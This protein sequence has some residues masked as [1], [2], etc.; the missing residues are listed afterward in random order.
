MGSRSEINKNAQTEVKLYLAGPEVFL[1]DAAE[2]AQ[3]QKNLCTRYGFIGL[4]PM[5]NNIDIENGSYDTAMRIYRSDI[6]Q[7]RACVLWLPIA[8][9]FAAR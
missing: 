2:H 6:G 1:S 7:I 5:D 8:I 4:H 9:H 3:I